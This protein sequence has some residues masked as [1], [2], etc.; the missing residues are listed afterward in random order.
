[1]RWNSF[2][3]LN[4]LLLVC[5]LLYDGLVGWMKRGLKVCGHGV[6]ERGALY[7]HAC[8][9][10]GLRTSGRGYAPSVSVVRRYRDDPQSYR[11]KGFIRS[12]GPFCCFWTG[13][14]IP[15]VRV[16]VNSRRTAGRPAFSADWRICPARGGQTFGSEAGRPPVLPLP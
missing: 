11:A 7:V 12:N 14:P 13:R 1:M 3:M 16:S 4:G 10:E 6:S 9:P 8:M 15:K 5:S 2:F